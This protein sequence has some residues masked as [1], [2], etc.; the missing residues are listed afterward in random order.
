MDIQE[1]PTNHIP[2]HEASDSKAKMVFSVILVIV[3]FAAMAF[4]GL[5]WRSQILEYKTN[6]NQRDQEIAT[7]KARVDGINNQSTSNTKTSTEGYLNIKEWGVKLKS[8]ESA[9]SYVITTKQ[10]GDKTAWLT[11]AEAQA[12]VEF[13]ECPIDKDDQVNHYFLA[14][15]SRYKTKPESV[16]GNMKYLGTKDGYYFYSDHGNGVCSDQAHLNQEAEIL[17]RLYDAANTLELE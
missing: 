3:T 6:I 10:D 12:L 17:R 11:N 8:T 14:S 2:V 5:K 4:A 15:I 13:A 16:V 7:L 1:Q 9:M